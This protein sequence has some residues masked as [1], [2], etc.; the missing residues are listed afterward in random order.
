MISG[1][2]GKERNE[3]LMLDAETREALWRRLGEALETYARGID[4]ERVTPVLDLEA[5]R[6]E[7]APFDFERPSPPSV[8]LGARFWGRGDAGSVELLKYVP[9]RAGCHACG[10]SGTK[11]EERFRRSR[12]PSC[13]GTE[14][15]DT[16]EE[17]P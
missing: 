16:P 8:G 7:L 3:M 6:R 10:V 4:R 5:I 17:A 1:S 9:P 12:P 15:S 11:E 14:S 13:R 2:D